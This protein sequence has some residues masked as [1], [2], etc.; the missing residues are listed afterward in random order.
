MKMSEAEFRAKRRQVYLDEESYLATT[1]QFANDSLDRTNANIKLNVE[2]EALVANLSLIT[3]NAW[4]IFQ[5][6]YTAGE[7]LIV[8]AESLS[9]ILELNEKYAK[10]LLD[11]PDDDYY[12]PFILDDAI[13][14]YVNYVNLL[15][16]AILLHREDLI[17]RIYGL[18]EDTDYDGVDLVIE[19]LLT[20]F[21]PDRPD[22]D[23]CLWDKPYGRLLEAKY[24]DSAA[25]QVKG[26]KKYVKGWYP[27]MKGEAHFWGAH[28]TL[29]VDGITPYKGYWAMCA[30]AFSYLFDIDDSSYRDEIVYPK[31]L[32]SYARSKPRRTV[33][34]AQ[35][36]VPKELRRCEGGKPCPETGM[37]FTPASANSQ[38]IFKQGEVMPIYEGSD[39]GDTIWYWVQG[40]VK[41]Q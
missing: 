32:A 36:L 13:D 31:D 3:T 18:I 38:R 39:Y 5:L 35:K 9:S 30:A 24:A 41:H 15:S 22:I 16:A 27:A 21:I 10:A 6:R 12:P 11:L 1:K 14:I 2:G 7:D 20:L 33:A 29:I 28:E 25:E 40:Q 37:W 34:E 8:L 17:P 4:D 26:M 19:D 23:E